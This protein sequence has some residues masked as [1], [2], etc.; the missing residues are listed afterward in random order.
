MLEEKAATRL[1][2]I[3]RIAGTTHFI[4]RLAAFA[5]LV[6]DITGRST[7]VIGT[8]F[9]N[10][11]RTHAQSIVGRFVHWVPLVLPCDASKTFLEWLQAVHVRVFE[12]LGHS[13]L[14][15]DTI[16]KQLQA[17]GIKP[18][19]TAITFMLSRDNSEQQFGNLT[20]SNDIFSVGTMPWGW[21]FYVDEKAPANCHVRFD[22]S[23]CERQD[24]RA[25]LDRYVELLEI[26]AREPE[27][28]IATLLTRLDPKPLRLRWAICAAKS[29]ELLRW[30]LM[31]RS[32]KTW[33]RRPLETWAS[34]RS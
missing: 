15:F 3:A 1:D 24:M 2:E 27:V 30:K 22:A 5:A 7:V 29:K 33:I 11:N 31:R 13:E 17:A 10:R 20:I 34:S 14:P 21:L 9:D 25:L 26:A 32:L 16:Q 28:P 4:V 23:R 6:A 8:F 18:P 19:E 12:T